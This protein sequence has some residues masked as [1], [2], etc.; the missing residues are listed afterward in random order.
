MN[1]PR[2][3]GP[4][5]W[6]LTSMI[7]SQTPASLEDAIRLAA[8]STKLTLKI[9]QQDSKLK[10]QTAW[11]DILL[12]KIVLNFCE[13]GENK[14]R[15]LPLKFILFF[16]YFSISFSSQ[17]QKF[18]KMLF[19]LCFFHALVQERRKFG[20]LGWNIPYEFNESDLR[21]SL[22]QMLVSQLW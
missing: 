2:D 5:C 10:N 4:T 9:D 1:R 3:W 21:I 15:Y 14:Q 19:G 8:K 20:P 13:K 6:D 11:V 16:F 22:R 18:H 17:P 7:P 12:L